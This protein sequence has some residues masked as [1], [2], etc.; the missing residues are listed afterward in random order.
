MNAYPSPYGNA[1]PYGSNPA[2]GSAPGYGYSARGQA[3]DYV[4]P[5]PGKTPGYG[6]DYTLAGTVNSTEKRDGVDDNS[7]S[8]H[9]HTG[10]TAA[11]PPAT[12]ASVPK[13]AGDV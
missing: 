9:S 2:L 12:G 11:H 8:G 6:S 7:D 3:E 5:Y 1:G 10:D 13:L 4:P